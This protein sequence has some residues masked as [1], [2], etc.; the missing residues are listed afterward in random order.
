MPEGAATG[1]LYKV[2]GGTDTS[3]VPY[4]VVKTADGIWDETVAPDLSNYLDPLTMPHAL[5]RLEDGTFRF[6]PFT[7]GDRKVGDEVTNP[8]PGFVGRPI[9]RA[10]VNQNRLAFLYDENVVMSGAGDFG[11]FFRLSVLDYL[12]S[13]PI[14][15]AA[16]STKVSILNDAVPFNDGVMLFADQ[17][18]F[19]MSNGEAG[20]S[21]SSLAIKPITNYEVST[22]VTPVA[23]GSEVYFVS[24]SSG[25]ATV[26]EYTRNADSD[27]TSASDIT[28]HVSRYIPA[29]VTKLIPAGD[30][31]ALF[32]LTSGDPSAIYVYQF[33][34]VDAGTKAQSAWHRWRLSPEDTVVSAGYAS[35]VLTLVLSRP[36]G[37]YLERVQLGSASSGNITDRYPYLDRKRTVAGTYDPETERTAI[38]F[39][40]PILEPERFVLVAGGVPQAE[41]G[42]LWA[43]PSTLSVP[44]DVSGLPLVAGYR[45]TTLWR[46]SQPYVRRPDGTAVVSGRLQLRTLK[47]AYLNTASFRALVHPY[48]VGRTPPVE[49]KFSGLFVDESVIGE[50][51]K[52]NGDVAVTVAGHA[53]TAVV[54][55]VSDTPFGCSF[56]SAEWEAFFWAR[57]RP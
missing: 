22:R 27:A 53:E 19:G 31:N 3:F 43:N 36:S 12:D 50:R 52:A 41:A 24:D 29:G 48:G 57:A 5:V 49:F 20:L 55:I 42:Y 2:A 38:T 33:Y 8:V 7:W 23:L 37:V 51:P 10:F 46:P 4:Y 18:Q 35:G 56:Q 16:T 28:A 54:D 26:R 45:F 11:Q 47:M 25:H 1:A 30:L 32:V 21:A 40:D 17:T 6:A 15:A 9:R 14:D 44:G 39:A 13:D 34:W